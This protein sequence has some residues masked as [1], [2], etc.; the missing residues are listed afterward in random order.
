MTSVRLEGDEVSPIAGVAGVNNHLGGALEMAAAGWAVI[1]LHTPIDGGCD[2]SK[3]DCSSP[4]KHPRTKNGLS[5]ATTDADQIRRWWG[6]WP[7]ANIGAVVPDGYVVVDVDVADVETLFAAD[8]LPQ[9]AASRTG[10]GWHHIYRTEVPVRPKVGVRAHVDL[11]GPGSYIVVPPSLHVSGVRYEWVIPIEEEIAD[12]PA[13]VVAV[14]R[15]SRPPVDR[16]DGSDNTIPQGKRNASLTSLAGSMRRP[17]MTAAEI[18]AALL[19]VNRR[20]QP[21][22]P[23]GAVRRI[24]ASV[25]R[26]PPGSG[27][28]RSPRP[29]SDAGDNVDPVTGED[30]DGTEP[31]DPGST[32]PAE[33]KRSQATQLVELAEGVELFH[34]PDGTAYARIE[35][36]DHREVWPL[37][38]GAIR[39]WLAGTYYRR[40]ERAAGGQAIRDAVEV[41]AARALFDGPECAVYVRVARTTD[42]IYLDLADPKW[43][44]VKITASGWEIVADSPTRFRR[45]DGVLRL[46]DPVR[47]G[48]IQE[49]RP[50]LNVAD[51]AQ[52]RLAVSWLVAAIRGAGPY[53]VLDIQGEQG[54]AKS[55]TARAQRRVIDPNASPDRAAPRNEHDL[56]I[57]AQNSLVVSLDNVS[58]LP[59]WLSDALARLATGAGFA[60]RMLYSDGEEKLFYG[61]R[62]I[63]INAI[64]DVV[65]RSDLLDRSLVL[66]LPRIA[67]QSRRTEEE[68]WA[69]FD[70]AHPRILGGLLDAVAGALARRPSVRLKSPPRMADFATWAVAAEPALGWPDGAFMRAYDGNRSSA[71]ELA[72]EASSVG[73][74][75]RAL[76]CTGDWQ[77]T[78]TELLERLT[79][80]AGDSI[81]HR[82][83]WPADPRALSQELARLAPNLR[84][85][86]IGFER[87][88]TGKQR[89][90]FL[91]GLQSSV[92][93]VS[94]VV[95][96]LEDLDAEAPALTQMVAASTFSVS[97]LPAQTDAPD[98]P[99]AESPTSANGASAGWS[100]RAAAS[101]VPA[102]RADGSIFCGTC[103]PPARRPTR[104]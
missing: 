94:S 73:S 7:Q 3:P 12:A 96:L 1:P 45:P 71:H 41:L 20:C 55:S 90:I 69:D 39:S 103:H 87:K 6:M 76:L 102:S 91:T 31:G 27:R 16:P 30:L 72:L 52:W 46:P 49:L 100:C 88:P 47:G 75:V 11:R 18:E 62:P 99:D 65:T 58:K 9:T 61:A 95:R 63:I 78:S 21:P 92:S 33:G 89:L 84:A 28:T 60:A 98:A 80:I 25:G 97:G 22:L 42:A 93:S 14:A 70:V 79:S 8:E 82:K 54:S 37:K 101:H 77:G 104:P 10:R 68:F 5:D 24:A 2:C 36:G 29:V 26:Y 4:G 66:E 64:G 83:D 51:D 35:Q 40:H 48:S 19:A 13:W 59:D 23:D 56:A 50:F 85:V 86:G 15:S 34:A 17:G 81:A 74:P 53:P 43:R 67:D 57:A 32:E 38:S 44:A